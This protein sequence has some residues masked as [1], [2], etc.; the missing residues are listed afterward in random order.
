[1]SNHHRDEPEWLAA[2]NPG[3]LPTRQQLRDFLAA[4]KAVL[5]RRLVWA[6]DRLRFVGSY[7]RDCGCPHCTA[8]RVQ[9]NG[10]WGHSPEDILD[11]HLA[12]E[13]AHERR[14]YDQLLRHRETI[15]RLRLWLVIF[16][17]LLV[18]AEWTLRS[19]RS[20]TPEAIRARAREIADAVKEEA[21]N[22][23]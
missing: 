18:D 10:D 6:L 9:I 11:I 4:D 22:N 20:V 7:T 21:R 17:R 2:D 8:I 13:T 14:V 19:I 16:R 15:E 23:E 5:Q 3:F 1:M 12:G